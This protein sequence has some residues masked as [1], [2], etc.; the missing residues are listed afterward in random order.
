M[1]RTSIPIVVAAFVV[2]LS[3]THV[4]PASAQ[5]F[6]A[7]VNKQDRAQSLLRQQASRRVCP[8]GTIKNCH[9][10]YPGAKPTCRI[11]CR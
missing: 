10:Y 4:A 7:Q 5:T 3:T 6:A 9:P 2:A 1:L 11:S 8:N